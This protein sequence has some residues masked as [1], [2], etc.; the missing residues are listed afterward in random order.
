MPDNTITQEAARASVESLGAAGAEMGGPLGII[1][2]T[3]LE[4]EHTSS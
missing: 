1:A 2:E 3:S 4:P